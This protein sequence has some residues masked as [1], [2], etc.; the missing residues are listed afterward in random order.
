MLQESVERLCQGLPPVAATAIQNTT[1]LRS[2]FLGLIHLQRMQE[3]QVRRMESSLESM[4]SLTRRLRDALYEIRNSSLFAE[5]GQATF[6]RMIIERVIREADLLEQQQRTLLGQALSPRFD[7]DM[8][9]TTPIDPMLAPPPQ[10]RKQT[11][12]LNQAWLT[13]GDNLQSEQRFYSR[14]SANNGSYLSSHRGPDTE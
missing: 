3:S 1:E 6:E 5:L 4:N 2:T 8:P 14:S 13:T 10:P 12:P 7:K 9:A 11:D